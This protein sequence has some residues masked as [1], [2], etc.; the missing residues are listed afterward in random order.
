MKYLKFQ[1]YSAFVCRIGF[2]CMVLSCN[3]DNEDNFLNNY[4]LI[5]PSNFPEVTYNEANNPVTKAGFE[6][7]KKLFFDPRLSL[8]GSISCNNCHQQGRAFSDT[9]LHPL[10]IGID[11]QLGIRNAPPLFNLAFRKEFM[12]DGGITH[13]DFVAINA[14]E[15]PIEMGDTLENIINKLNKDPDYKSR[16]K[17]VFDEDVITAPRML[18]A[19]S[20]FMLLMI[21]NNS[22]Y[23]QYSNNESNVNFTE[24]ERRGLD[25]FDT[26]CAS[27]HSGILFTDQTFRNNGISKTFNDSGRAGISESPSD[28]GKFMVPSLRNIAITNPYMHNAQFNTLEEVLNHYA[29]GVNPSATLDKS[30]INDDGTLGIPLTPKEQEDIIAFLHTLTDEDFISDI[31]FRN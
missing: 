19:F 21:S 31:K 26:H 28:V 18:Q 27:C 8:D 13:L 4:T 22:K 6:L 9:P 23:D 5:R 25:L 20:Q 7:G 15:S 11:N 10:S 3:S 12:W 2:I 30:L 16:F 1:S 17:N 29:N 24:S 14:L